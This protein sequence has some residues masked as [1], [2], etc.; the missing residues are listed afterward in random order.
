MTIILVL[1]DPAGGGSVK[2]LSDPAGEGSVKV[3]SDPAGMEVSRSY[4]TLLSELERDLVRGEGVDLFP[5]FLQIMSCNR[6][7]THCVLISTKIDN[8]FPV[9]R[10]RIRIKMAT[11][12]PDPH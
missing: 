7:T 8:F 5:F 11:L 9:F 10:I 1:S 2:V 4:L 12:D 6:E 3:L